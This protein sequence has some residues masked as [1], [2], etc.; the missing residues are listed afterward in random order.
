MSRRPR[1]GGRGSRGSGFARP[2]ILGTTSYSA[3]NYFSTATPGGVAG[4]ASGFWVAGLCTLTTISGSN[5][6]FLASRLTT[7]PGNLGWYL[8]VATG[9][10]FAFSAV[11]GAASFVVAPTYTLSGSDVGKTHML[12]GVHDGTTARLYVARAEI[13]TG[14]AITG[15]S[16]APSSP[17]LLGERV[18]TSQPFS[19]GII[20]GA[21]G[22]H[23]V[24][25]LAQVQAYFDA[26]KL[27][28]RMVAMPSVQTDHIWNTTS[29]GTISDE[30]GSDNLTMTGT[31]TAARTQPIAWAW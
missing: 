12:V 8:R 16:P 29:A 24:P 30:V 14:T 7:T 4:V 15:Y 27:A 1:S 2:A 9:T 28:K 6:Q 13:S 19:Q 20:H 11:S 17:Q 22:G 26:V 21:A 3:A 25:T 31:L 10:A 5:N 23:A 18:S